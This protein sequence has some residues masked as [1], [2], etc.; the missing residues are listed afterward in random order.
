MTLFTLAAVVYATT[1]VGL[2]VTG[3]PVYDAT[4]KGGPGAAVMIVLFTLL[5]G[6]F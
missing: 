3:T 2:V 6:G 4:V 5:G 1:V